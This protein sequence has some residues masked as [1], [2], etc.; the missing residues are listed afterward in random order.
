LEGIDNR[1]LKRPVASVKFDLNKSNFEYDDEFTSSVNRDW[2]LFYKE[3]REKAIN[4][5]KLKMK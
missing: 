3:Y 2:I 5:P 1:I 4:G